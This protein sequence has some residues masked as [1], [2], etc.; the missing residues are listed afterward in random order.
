MPRAH[1]HIPPTAVF[2]IVGAVAC[3]SVLDG[4]I[5]S[6]AVRHPVPL[7]VWARWGFQVVQREGVPPDIRGTTQFASVC[8]STATV[9]T[10]EL[11]VAARTDQP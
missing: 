1:V 10:L 11:A 5:K 7:L 4:I 3:F 9:M 8:P 2:M 6:L